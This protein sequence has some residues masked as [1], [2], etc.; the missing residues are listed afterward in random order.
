MDAKKKRLYVSKKDIKKVTQSVI[1]QLVALAQTFAYFEE[2]KIV[3]TILHC[4]YQKKK[5]NEIAKN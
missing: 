3:E 4:S 5:K 2:T 1:D